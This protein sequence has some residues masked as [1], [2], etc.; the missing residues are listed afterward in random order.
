MD[1]KIISLIVPVFNE[2]KNI[3]LLYEKFLK[4]FSSF[5]NAY[6]YEFIVID[7]GSTDGTSGVIEDI[8]KRDKNFKYLEF[9][10]NFGKEI[11]LSAGIDMAIGDAVLMIDADLQH[12]L[13]LF[14]EF[15][16]KWKNGAEVVVGVR[17][18]NMGEGWV[19]KYGSI[20]FYKIMSLIGETKI[21]P[22]AT[23][24]RLIDKKVVLAFRRFTEHSRMTR[25][26]IDWLGFRRE[27]I[28]FDAVERQHGLS[29]YNKIKL[30]RLAFSAFISHS[31]LPL[32]LAG[33]L[34]MFITFFSGLV[35]IFL[36]SGKFIFHNIFAMSFTGTAS[37][38]VLLIF[39]VGIVLTC[40]G[41]VA[42][43]I[44]NIKDEVANRPHY[45]VRKSNIDD[46]L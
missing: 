7:D 11:A 44:A 9:S 24:Y 26:L 15:L 5:L 43:Y 36:L 6:T 16:R 4:I 40:L 2:E 20:L 8:A 17:N 29:Q 18:K 14:P 25:G 19:K 46:C 32:K 30:M 34:G 41:L 35:G 37:L 39:L 23:D 22:R 10:R 21:T 38:A 33:Y 45:V 12:P 42:L 27:Y 28:Y 1:K 31:L 13:E 3:V